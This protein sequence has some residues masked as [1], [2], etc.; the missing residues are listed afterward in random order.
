MFARGL[1]SIEE[2]EKNRPEVK[3]Y[4]L[5]YKKL[6]SGKLLWQNHCQLFPTYLK[7]ECIPVGCVLS[8][9]VAVSWEGGCLPR[10]G[11]LPGGMSAQGG[12]LPREWRCVNPGGGRVSAQ[13]RGV[14]PGGTP[15]R[16]E[17]LP[18]HNLFR[19]TT[20]ADACENITFPQL[21]SR[22]G[23]EITRCVPLTQA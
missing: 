18:K 17:C 19:Q 14:C 6:I 21:L 7:Q 3:I 8:A 22:D 10:R 5:S 20:V 12:C 4:F 1:K 13:E 16:T 15:P 11:C 2:F 9:T 23:K